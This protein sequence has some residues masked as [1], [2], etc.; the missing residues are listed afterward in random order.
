M[1]PHWGTSRGVRPSPRVVILNGPAGVGKTT[2][3]RALAETVANGACIHGDELRDFIVAREDGAVSTGLG[4]RNGASVA[5]NFVDAGYELVVFEYV[6]ETARGIEEF[7]QA[8]RSSVPVHFFTL[9]APL[10]IVLEREA[11]W[12]RRQQRQPLGERVEAC[13][14]KMQPNLGT[15]GSVVPTDE[16][17][18]SEVVADILR[19]CDHHQ[20]LLPAT[21]PIA[22]AG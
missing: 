14:Q 11:S 20:G 9:W 22:L 3:A 2:T 10:E 6:F 15:L 16:L 18:V 12:T 21:E 13:Y 8:Y 7:R 4:Y 5:Q 19:R 1:Q 17:E